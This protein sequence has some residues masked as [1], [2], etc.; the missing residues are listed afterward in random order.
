V[1]GS[2]RTWKG[3]LPAR[4]IPLSTVRVRLVMTKFGDPSVRIAWRL[5]LR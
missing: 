5:A 3:K 2:A 4:L 1:G